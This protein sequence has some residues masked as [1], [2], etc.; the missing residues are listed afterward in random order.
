M[1]NKW[2]G[3]ELLKFYTFVIH[4][5]GYIYQRKE[6]L[7]SEE[8]G[9]Q[10]GDSVELQKKDNILKLVLIKKDEPECVSEQNERYSGDQE[11]CDSSVVD[12]ESS[13]QAQLATKTRQSKSLLGKRDQKKKMKKR[14]KSLGGTFYKDLLDYIN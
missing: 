10:Q 6:T 7:I 8:A 12:E 13:N 4:N 5:F 3:E 2:Q 1:G 11:K 14:T 9:I